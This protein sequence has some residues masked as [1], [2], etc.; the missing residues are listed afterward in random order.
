MMGTNLPSGRK[1][2][3]E[4]IEARIANWSANPAAIGLTS[5][6]VTNLLNKAIATR[7]DFVSVESARVDA[8]NATQDFYTSADD[9][10]ATAAPMVAT[11]KSFAESSTTPGAVYAAAEVLP[12]DPPSPIGPPAQPSINNASLDG[13]GFVTI[14]FSATGAAGTAWQV[15]R[16]LSSE[17]SYTII[18]NADVRT[19]SFVDTSVPAGSASAMYQVTGIRGSIVGPAS[20]GF[21]VKFGQAAPAANANA[22]A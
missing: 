5:A 7:T 3:L 11:I 10:H 12:A 13:N 22:A 2:T 16:Q 14:D 6:A 19:K 4:W 9:L 21:E 8:R 15:A 20:F 17:S 1:Q 18:G